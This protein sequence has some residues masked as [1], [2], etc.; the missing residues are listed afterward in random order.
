MAFRMPSIFAILFMHCVDSVILHVG[1][2]CLHAPLTRRID[3]G[4]PAE[5]MHGT[6]SGLYIS[7]F[8]S[9]SERFFK[10]AQLSKSSTTFSCPLIERNDYA[11]W[12]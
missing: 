1:A 4:L 6:G 10:G 3:I 11:F 5:N 9:I 12:C 8:Y 2:W 7:L